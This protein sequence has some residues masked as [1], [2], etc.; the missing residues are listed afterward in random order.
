MVLRNIIIAPITE[1]IVYRSVLAPALHLALV[2]SQHTLRGAAISS[3]SGSAIGS[4]AATYSPWMVVWVNPLW[5]GL[6]HMH[7][8]IEKIHSGWPV[9]N[10]LISTAVQLTYTSIF[11]CIATLLLLRTGSIYTSI[12]SHCIC[13]SVGLPDTSFLQP[14]G[15]ADSSEYSCLHHDR[16]LHLIL[17]ALGLVLFTLSIL[18]LTETFAKDSIYWGA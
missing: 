12:L 10:A 15:R 4:A 14:P 3:S 17:H 11:G 13:N 5:F 1:E 16:Y 9:K 7:H 8:L 6:A 2:S 18:P